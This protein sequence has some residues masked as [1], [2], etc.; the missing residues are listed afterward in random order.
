MPLIFRHLAAA[1]LP[2][3]A[4][5]AGILAVGIAVQLPRGPSPVI[6]APPVV[7]PL[8]P[9]ARRRRP[10]PARREAS[11]CSADR[12]TVRVPATRVHRERRRSASGVD[13]ADPRRPAADASEPGAV[14]AAL[15]HEA[16]SVGGG[17]AADAAGGTG[18]PPTRTPVVGT[19]RTAGRRARARHRAR[20]PHDG[21]RRR[22]RRSRSHSLAAEARAKQARPESRPRRREGRRS[23][24]RKPSRWRPRRTRAEKAEGPEGRRR[25]R[26][27]QASRDCREGPARP[28]DPARREGPEASVPEHGK[29]PRRTTSPRA[30][31]REWHDD[32]RPT[33]GARRP[34]RTAT[35]ATTS[36]DDHGQ[37]QGEAGSTG[38]DRVAAATARAGRGAA[39]AADRLDP[40]RQ[41]ACRS[42]RRGGSPTP[43]SP[44]R[45]ARTPTCAC[46]SRPARRRARRRRCSPRPAPGRSSSRRRRS[47]SVPRGG[48]TGRPS[49]GCS[50]RARRCISRRDGRGAKTIPGVWV[51]Q[52]VEGCA[53]RP[54]RGHGGR[55]APGDG[56]GVPT[57]RAGARSTACAGRRSRSPATSSR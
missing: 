30:R 35:T 46:R 28:D 27:D 10:A 14:A 3:S 33:T 7:S 48:A 57:R 6:S 50:G 20:K 9:A 21:R 4:T 19:S 43:T 56:V 23:R 15:D 1:V 37:R 54:R 42:S 36:H 2:L 31:R 16:A 5:A 38:R 40:H 25:G 49:H 18:T 47:F 44:T 41:P 17:S 8:E 26:K 32:Q 51:G 53:G 34:G 13:D 29:T 55:T 52:R 22:R 12:P 45:R 24:L 11:A 39:G